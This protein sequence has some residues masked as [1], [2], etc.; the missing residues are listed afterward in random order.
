MGNLIGLETYTLVEAGCL[1]NL[2]LGKIGRWLRGHKVEG[3]PYERLLCLGRSE[4]SSGAIAAQRSSHTTGLLM[5]P[6]RTSPGLVR[7]SKPPSPSPLARKVTK[8]E[9]LTTDARRWLFGGRWWVGE[10]PLI[11]VSR[12]GAGPHEQTPPMCPVLALLGPTTLPVASAQ[13]LPSHGEEP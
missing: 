7:C 2:R 3:R 4:G 9:R 12:Y 8:N 11:A 10:A 5:P 1:L 6:Q 13:A